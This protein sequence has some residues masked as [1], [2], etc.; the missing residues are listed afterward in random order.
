MERPYS[1]DKGNFK[2]IGWVFRLFSG[3]QQQEENKKEASSIRAFNRLL[4]IQSSLD[5]LDENI[6]RRTFH[7][8]RLF[9]FNENTMTQSRYSYWT[10]KEYIQNTYQRL[11]KD[12]EEV[13]EFT[14]QKLTQMNGPP[15]DNVPEKEEL[16]P[17]SKNV[18]LLTLAH[19]FLGNE[20][21]GKAAANLIRVHFLNEYA[22]EDEDE[23][24]SARRIPDDSHLLDF[25]SDQGYSFPSQ[26]RVS[27]VVSKYN[28][29]R[30][31]NTSDL[32]KTDITALLDSIRMLGR[33]QAL[34][35]KEYIDLQGIVSEFLEYLVTSPTGIHLAQMTDHRGALYDLQVIAMAAFTDD[36]RLF[37]RVANRCRMR[38][39]KQFTSDGE[40]Q[41][42][43]SWVRTRLLSGVSK[44]DSFEEW[45][46][47]LHYQTLNLQYWTLLAR[48]IQNSG[49]AK[50]IWY[51]QTKDQGSISH[52]VVTHLSKYADRLPLLSKEDADFVKSRLQPLAHMA[53]D[54]FNTDDE[55][56]KWLLKHKSDF[57][58]KWDY[59][60]QDNSSYMKEDAI[61]GRLGT[62]PYWMLTLAS[63]DVHKIN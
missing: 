16:G 63:E 23:Y 55:S 26:S 9:L 43:E 62:P 32:T 52:A 44:D 19:H 7:H 22:V 20:K 18:T 54:A 38:I 33:M 40:Q 28:R 50:D 21:Y 1:K 15:F 48:G 12:A 2:N 5:S 36:V 24:T 56:F 29:H 53:L 57:G 10:K 6:A 42:E 27:R 34:T 60:E 31:L 4:A 25:L 3:N 37:L 49:I 59:L 61:K 13:W 35:H 30:I 51:Y 8:D 41:H 39:G 47:V 14:Q 45:R 58:T 46:A 17:L 11:E